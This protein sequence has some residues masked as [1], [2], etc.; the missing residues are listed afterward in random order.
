MQMKFYRCE[1]C[2]NLVVKIA[3]SGVPMMCC[4]R[5][6]TE[7]QPNT[8]DAAVEKHVPQVTIHGDIVEVQVG[9]A[10]HPMIEAHYIQM[11]CL[12][13]DKGFQVRQLIPNSEPTAKFAL[14]GAKALAVYAFC[15]LHG[16]WVKEL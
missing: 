14:G 3:D 4:G 16:L 6:M 1:E 11:I 15:N 7:L 13:T 10:I 12:Q 8:M 2:G 9:S 5:P